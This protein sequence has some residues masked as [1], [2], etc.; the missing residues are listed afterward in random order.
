MNRSVSNRASLALT[1]LTALAAALPLRAQ[2]AGSEAAAGGGGLQEVLVTATRREER[3]QDVPIS[4]TAFSQEQM[5]AQGLRS[6]DDLTRLSPG[7]SFSRNGMGSSANYNDENSD[8]SFRGVESQAGA[9]TTGIYIDD[10]PVQSRHLAF[11]AVNVFPALFDIDRVEV[12]RGPQGTLFGA[13]AEGGAVRFLMPQPGLTNYSAYARAE[14]A[15]TR[16]GAPSYELGA[17]YGGPIV[18]NEL[19]FRVSASYRRDGGWVDR[20][21]YALEPTSDPRLPNPVFNGVTGA[22]TNWWE[23]VTFRAAL[24]WAPTDAVA[25]TPSFYYQRFKVNDTAAYWDPLSNAGSNVFYNGNALKN[26]AYDPFWLAAVKVDWSLPWAQLTSN[27]SFYYRNQHSTSDYTQYLRA[28]YAYYDLLQTIYPQPG[29]AGYAPFQDNQRNFYQEVRLASKDTGSR[30]LWNAGVFYSHLDENIPEDIYDKTID[31]ETGGAVCS[32]ALPCPDGHIYFQPWYRVVDRQLAGFGELTYKLTDTFKV[33]GGVRVAHVEYTGTAYQ[34]GAFIG[35]P[36][37][38][39]YQTASENPITPKA[40]LTWQPDRDN[41][42]YASAAKGYRVGGTNPQ[43][44][45]TCEIDLA[46][47]GLPVGADGLHHVPGVYSSDSLWSYELGTKNAFLEHRL[48]VNASVFYI[49]WRNI[50]QNVYLPTCGAQFTANLGKAKSSGGDLEILFRP[51][52]SLMLN[53]SA[54]YTDAH[55]TRSSCAGTLEYDPNTAAC[56]SGGMAIAAP[57]VTEGNRLFGAPWTFTAALEK[58]F[59]WQQKRPY[60]RADFQYAT[61]Q[62]GLLPGQD[63]RNALYDTT[64]P[65]LPITKN[66]NL[67]AGM[68]WS[69]YDLSVFVQNALDQHPVLFK[70]RDLAAYP[71]NLYFSRGVRP[72]TAGVTATYS[73]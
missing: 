37:I 22:N 71:D 32:A 28:T 66:L 57:I 9:S 39:S 60:F 42:V 4:I 40:V 15:T 33:T 27:T 30:L 69:G 7:V 56:S 43:V 35:V 67:R 2:T 68:R 25:V 45:A 44:G 1:A 51:V 46:S 26:P 18:D 8:I 58:T 21:N 14:L 64:L 6:I 55:Y 47:L 16:D 70:S 24:K 54:A 20:V 61:A 29:D 5:D 65:G 50:Q 34:A 38:T 48:Q 59:L 31:A 62:T 17:A 19:G 12:L 36:V 73:Y 13:G 49:D 53:V 63:P 52:E 72:L 10:S 23:T 3:L 41:M 11:G